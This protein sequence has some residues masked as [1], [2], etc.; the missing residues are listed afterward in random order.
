MSPVTQADVTVYVH[1]GQ[2]QYQQQVESIPARSPS[3]C[4]PL[5]LGEQE[6]QEQQ[7]HSPIAPIP[8]S[9]TRTS[10]SPNPSVG[11]APSQETSSAGREQSLAALSAIS[12]ID[13]YRSR[14]QTQPD[15]ALANNTG[16]ESS[17]GN[18][19]TSLAAPHYSTPVTG[20]Y[21]PGVQYNP[22]QSYGIPGAPY[23]Q[24]QSP[25]PVKTE[26]SSDVGAPQPPA[27]A[28]AAVASGSK[29]KG[30]CGMK[31]TVFLL[32]C[33]ILFLIIAGAV[34]GGVFGSGVLKPKFVPSI[35]PNSAL[36]LLLSNNIM[37]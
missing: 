18:N 6:R 32:L 30:V 2:Q 1:D 12:P 24:A 8:E 22:D 21:A 20:Y 31:V 29:K 4:A 19:H 28:V 13:Q 36:P 10:H 11:Y 25:P 35:L 33:V 14:Y 23:P 17:Y 26:Y 3:G 5:A 9:P 16:S 27:A 7:H 34:L 37:G 15:S